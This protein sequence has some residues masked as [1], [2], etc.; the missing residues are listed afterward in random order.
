VEH[1]TFVDLCDPDGAANP[2][3]V[4]WSRRPWH[5][6]RVDGPWGR[7][8]R[9]H[10]WCVTSAREVVSLTFADLD[11]VGAAVVV[12]ADRATGRS[13]R[14]AVVRPGGWGAA[15]PDVADRGRVEIDHGGVHLALTEH[16]DRARLIARTPRLEVD[17]TAVRPEG[18][19]TLGVAVAWGPRRFA[20][21]GKHNTLPASGTISVDGERRAVAPG[22]FATLDWGRG[23]WPVRT[24][25]NWAS[26]SGVHRGRTIG[27][28][29]GARW[30]D[31]GG[32][33]ENALCVDGRLTKLTSEVEFRWD[34]RDPRRPWHLVGPDVDVT[35]TPELIEAL[36]APLAALGARLHVAFG[37]WRGRVLDVAFDDVF[38]WAEELR[39]HW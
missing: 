8:K 22:A 33:N 12:I 16:G 6:C 14:D 13:V 20:Y 1:E 19:D 2:A 32:A 28:N 5:R 4:G 23:V 27:V 3:A 29:L 30:T 7:R 38:G 37:T 21:T 39:A 24:A 36:P 10:Y 15:L 35:V 17:V 18:H 25:W 11:Y 34:R 26:A 31:G 9:W